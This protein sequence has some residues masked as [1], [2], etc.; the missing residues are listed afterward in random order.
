MT[1][2][3]M[4]IKVKIEDIQPFE[5]LMEVLCRHLDDVPPE[6]YKAIMAVVDYENG[7]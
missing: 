2:T 1:A 6:V 5:N 4:T 7:V 3:E